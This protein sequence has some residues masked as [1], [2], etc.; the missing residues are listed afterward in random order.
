[1]NPR[2]GQLWIDSL[3]HEVKIVAA[4]IVEGHPVIAYQF[5]HEAFEKPTIHLR[6]VNR[7]T[8]WRLV[9]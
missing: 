6:S 8:G 2:K 1:M 7:L 3:G 4:D 5:T 9:K